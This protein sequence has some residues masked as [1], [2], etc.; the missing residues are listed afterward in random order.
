MCLPRLKESL[1]EMKTEHAY[2][3]EQGRMGAHWKQKAPRYAGQN[4]RYQRN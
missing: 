4:Q 2:A 1:L 3:K